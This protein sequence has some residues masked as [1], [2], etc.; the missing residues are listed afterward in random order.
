MGL[1]PLTWSRPWRPSPGSSDCPRPVSS[2]CSRTL[3]RRFRDRPSLLVLDNFEQVLAAAGAIAELLEVCPSLGLLVTSREALHIRGE[4]VF[5]SH[6]CPCRLRSNPRVRGGDQPLEAIQ[7]FVERA[8]AVRPGFRLTDDN[9]APVA[10]ICRRLDGLPLGIELATA[11]I[12]LFAPETLRD[13]LASRLGTLDR[14][15]R[16]CRPDSRRCVPRS[17]GAT[18]CLERESNDSSSSSRSSR[19]SRSRRSSRSDEVGL[20]DGN[21]RSACGARVPA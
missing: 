8:R 4:H 18:G 16:T 20:R 1:Q 2:R 21:G 14:G 12:N 11:R 13:R 6:P 9:A 5:P 17:I 10:E 3:K 7:L 15:P 19:R